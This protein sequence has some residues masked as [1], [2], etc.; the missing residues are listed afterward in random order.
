MVA[1]H[2]MD[3]RY[4]S[5]DA[6]GISCNTSLLGSSF[7]NPEIRQELIDGKMEAHELGAI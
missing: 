5:F 7:R 3:R 1:R 6:L 4:L 2:T